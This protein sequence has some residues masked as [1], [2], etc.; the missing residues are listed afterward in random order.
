MVERDSRRGVRRGPPVAG[1]I[2]VT[3]GEPAGI[4]PDLVVLI[5]QQAR[6]QAWVVIADA[7]MLLA[8]AKLLGLPL[9]IASDLSDPACEAGRITVLHTPLAQPVVP[10]VLNAANVPGVLAALDAAIEGS[11]R[12]RFA[13][14]VTGPMQKSV[15]NEAGVAFSGHTEYLAEAARVEDVV[16]LLVADQLRVALATTHLPLRDVAD[17]LTPDLLERRLNIFHGHLVDWFGIAAPRILV[18]GLNPHAGESGH[19]GRE[20]VDIIAPVC[21]AMRDQG[22]QVAGPLPADTLFTPAY[23]ANA[24]GV[25]AMYHDQGLPVLKYAGFG[26]AV[27][28]TLGLPFIRTS[29]DHG[30]ALD[31]AGTGDVDCGSFAAALGLAGQLADKV[32]TSAAQVS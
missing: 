5:A 32:T 14:L 9:N 6:T 8:R 29:V 12:G 11:L 10:G 20:E 13:A 21:T 7:D 2:A 19:L 23:L 22:K 16:M 1:M 27:N 26:S 25:M 28:V 15:V 24:D 3:P 18:S 17:A 30:T 4:G 31:L